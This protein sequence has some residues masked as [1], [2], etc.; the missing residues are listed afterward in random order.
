VAQAAEQKR[1]RSR[2]FST[3]LLH[4][5]ADFEAE[6]LA[7]GA[8]T[9]TF[10]LS[11]WM[12]LTSVGIEEAW[13]G[14]LLVRDALLEVGGLDRCTEPIPLRA[15][16]ART[17]LISATVYLDGLLARATHALDDERRSVAAAAVAHIGFSGG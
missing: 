10:G 16:D 2:Q 9:L 3:A 6:D 17:A 15:S 5:V 13:A 14:V 4:G 1:G 7:H 12:R 8:L 11:A